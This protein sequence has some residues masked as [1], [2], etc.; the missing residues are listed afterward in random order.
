VRAFDGQGTALAVARPSPDVWNVQGHDGTVRVTYRV[1]GDRV[2]GTYLAIDR[3]H[4]HI[5]MPAA[6]MWAEGFEQRP[7]TVRIEAPSGLRWKAA[8]QLLPTIDPQQ[9]YAA[10]LQYLMDSPIEL[11]DHGVRTFVVDDPASP[12]GRATFR[13]AMH[14]TGS[15]ADLESFTASV[16]KIVRQGRQV[17]GEFP[18]FE[19]AHYSSIPAHYT[20]IADYL[21]HATGDAMEHRNSTVLTD[22]L[23]VRE[24]GQE[25]LS[26][27]AHEFFHAWNVERIRPKS[28]EPFRF[29]RENP[30]GELWLGEGFTSYYEHVIMRR[31]G[32]TTLAH[33]LDRFGGILSAIVSSGAPRIR[34]AEQASL[35]AVVFDGGR[36]AGPEDAFLS[37]Y[38]W[39]AGLGLALDLSLRARSGGQITLDDYMRALWRTYGKPGIGID[40]LV[41]TPYTIDEAR[42][43]LGAV[44]GDATFA[45]EF[46]RR[47]IQGHDLPDFAS[48]LAPAGIAW[49]GRQLVPVERRGRPLTRGQRAFRDAWLGE[50]P[51]D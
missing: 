28:L 17:V 38:T 13:V 12:G 44:A 29:D 8:T 21:P 3:T 24:A 9:F 49:N 48:L 1:S 31:A 39:G 47:F 2:D 15:N 11:S 46:F 6:L 5:N 18:A 26:T 30:S 27:V 42:R 22:N 45:R 43:L 50:I 40:G 16:R 34:T 7:A 23:R 51:S 25:L 14:H 19:T 32:L 37:Y 41:A 4:A 20:F 33:A 35:Q 36:P 10:N